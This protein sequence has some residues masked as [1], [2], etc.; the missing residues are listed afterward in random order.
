M[1]SSSS[2]AASS[3]APPTS[4]DASKRSGSKK[5]SPERR[6][7]SRPVH[8]VAALQPEASAAVD[9]TVGTLFPK[10]EFELSSGA[11][12][13]PGSVRIKYSIMGNPDGKKI[14]L[15]P[16]MSNSVHAVDGF[17][18]DD[19]KDHRGWWRRTIGHGPEFGIDLD[20]FQVIVGAPMG[21]PFGSTSPLTPGGPNAEEPLRAKF[22]LITPRDQALHQKLLLDELGI[23][24]V[25]AV[26]GGSMGGMQSLQFAANFPDMYDRFVAIAAT[27]QTSPGTVALRSVQRQA[28][29]MDP[30]FMNGE[31]KENPKHGLGIARMF[32]TICYRSPKEFDERFDWY[33]SVLEQSGDVSFEVERY[34]QHQALKFTHQVNYDA[35]CYLLL[36]QSMDLMDIGQNVGTFQEGA[37]RIPPSK[38]GMLLSYSTDR[39]TPAQDHERLARVLGQ[40]DVPVHF[41]VIESKFGHDAFLIENE[42][43]PL[44]I[45]LKAFLNASNTPRSA[46]AVHRLVKDMFEH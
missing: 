4:V 2:G 44:N 35:N 46:D 40:N 42:A 24:K 43:Q 29:R 16:S 1:A 45:R 36:S 21:S 34:L 8:S 30:D 10:N 25:F 14:L 3:S 5:E 18:P 23:E 7:R 13:A 19:Q 41:E 15:C 17:D 37:A 28:V 39:L 27:A 11:K 6:R 22:P 20:H 32:G 38:A 31:Y 33:P 26:V 9:V 12:L